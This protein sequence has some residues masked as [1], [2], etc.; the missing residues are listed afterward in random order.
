VRRTV[1]ATR[2]FFDALDRQLPAERSA[3]Q[4]SRSDFESYDLLE[5]VERF[6]TDWDELPRTI[7]DRHTT[8][9]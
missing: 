4:P 9:R 5:I 3:D 1:R 8:G 2:D 7:W 6:A